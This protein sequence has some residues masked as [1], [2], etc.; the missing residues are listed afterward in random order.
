MTYI[1]YCDHTKISPQYISGFVDGEGCFTLGISVNQKRPFGLC[2]TPSFSVSQ[3]YKSESIL[4]VIQN[5]FGCGFLRRDRFT[6]KYEVRSLP[7]LHTQ[8][9]PHF[10]QYPLYTQKAQDFI[11]FSEICHAL[12][13]NQQYT[14]AGVCSILEKAYT[15]NQNGKF[16]R[17][18]KHHWLRL[19]N[20][21]PSNEK[22]NE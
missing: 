10:C 13:L 6:T 15:M 7:V 14:S 16:R 12:S 1:L 5:F 3:H 20:S 8:I 21:F 9:L 19:V 4:R 2:L 22:V 17:S 18:A 11:L